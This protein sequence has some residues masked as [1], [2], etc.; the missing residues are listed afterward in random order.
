MIIWLSDTR[1][2]EHKPFKKTYNISGKNITLESWK[3]ALLIDWS[4]V[5]TDEDGNYLLTTAGINEKVKP[6]TDFFPMTVDFQEKYYATG[7]IGWNRFMKR[8][9]RPSEASIL[10]SRLIDRPIRPMFPKWTVNEV[11]IISTILSSS[12]TSDYGFYWITWAS[13]ALML[14]GTAEFEWPVS[15]ARII[16]DQNDEFKF[17][18]SIDDLKNAKLDLTIAWT[19]DAITM[20]ESQWQE[21]SED[22]VIKAFEYAHSIV[23]EFCNMQLDY[24]AEYSKLHA[25]PKSKIV[26]K[27]LPADYKM[28]I[29]SYV[30]EDKMTPLY[31]VWKMEFHEEM[32]K[33]WQEVKEWIGDTTEDP[34]TEAEIDE[35]VYMAIKKHMRTR[36]LNEKIRLDW[37]KTA[38]VR[39]VWWEFGILPRVHGSALFQRWVTQALTITTLGWPGD[40]QIIDD[41]FEENT[42]RY[43]HH[44]NFPPFSVGEVRMMRWPGRRE[45]GHGRL[46][47]KALE[48]VLPSL[49]EFP[50]FIRMVSE[51]TTC[52]GSSSMASICGSSMS[53]MDA[54][55]PIKNIV[56]WV[57]MW[58]IF[59][60]ENGK[61]EI[62]TDIQAQEDFLWDMDF[63][64]AGTIKWLTALQMD[65]K[66]KWL[67]M[68]VIRKVISQSQLA[69]ESIRVDMTK[70]LTTHRPELSPFAPFIVSMRIPVDK[71]REVIGKGWE[72]IQKITKEFE[73]KIDINDEGLL[74]VT[75]KTQEQGK[76]AI[77]YITKMLKWI[78]VWDTWIGK[79]AKILDWIGA[80][81]DLG[82][83]KSWMIHISKIA[84]ERV[85]NIGD[86]LK[87]WD[88]VEYKVISVDTVAG[89]VGLERVI[90]E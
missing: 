70:T 6:G 1:I 85:T 86:Y 78:E 48:P 38:E 9:S 75:A 27:H 16:V 8:E 20:V 60:E 11:Q 43:I 68:E 34:V 4:V 25:L 29:S 33:L 58:M 90:K 76:N 62:L 82:Q 72:T 87:V 67:S 19:L 24:V 17:D 53:M 12:G 10:N 36:V 39:P 21:V 46:A 66:I 7:K 56:S 51:I 74:S 77:D 14:S 42:K 47:E 80:I 44:Y 83:N 52:N 79:V 23:K 64:V 2:L 65:C 13:L 37:R 61:Y 45:I 28:K 89:K 22:L 55:V 41:M 26:V 30:T 54:W 50:Y 73:V 5:I 18:P 31:H 32:H 57:A 59:D 71:I 40:I 84:K 63:K 15:G 35:C 69:L 49:E 88:M 81:L 3:L